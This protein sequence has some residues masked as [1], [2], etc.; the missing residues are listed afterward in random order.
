MN[1]RALL[2][3]GL[4]LGIIIAGGTWY[5]F[6]LSSLSAKLAVEAAPMDSTIKIDG[7]SVSASTYRVK[8]GTHVV[9]VS[10]PGF[11]A[12]SK[13]FSPQKGEVL[14]AGFV[15]VSNSSSTASWY[16]AHS[17]DQRLAEKISGRL[18]Q[19]SS[20]AQ[21]QKLPLI[22]SLPLI[23]Q[24]FRIDFGQSKAH[25]NDPASV[26]IYITYYSDQGK[27]TALNW[28]KFK[29]YDPSKLEIIY[30][31]KINLSVNPAAQ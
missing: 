1:R 22:K 10:R 20:T 29:G 18:F 30:V 5:S 11:A 13:S 31:N 27:Q 17:A 7:R 16:Q 23:D 19:Q 14:Y 2:I 28:I 3:G 4:F 26:A 24:E 8:P 12:E 21:I 15:L 25:P 6:H 9:S